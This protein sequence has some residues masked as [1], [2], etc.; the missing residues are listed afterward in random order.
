MKVAG[1]CTLDFETIAWQEGDVV[2]ALRQ[3]R[4]AGLLIHLPHSPY[5][6]QSQGD[7]HHHAGIALEQLD[8]AAGIEGLAVALD[9]QGL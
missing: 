5:C 4:H 6:F 3:V 2:D 7:C 1:P 9:E 8:L